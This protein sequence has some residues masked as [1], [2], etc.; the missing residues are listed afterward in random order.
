M[1]AYDRTFY[2]VNLL[3][4][5]GAPKEQDGIEVNRMIKFKDWI[6]HLKKLSIGAVLF[7][8][9]FTSDTDGRD[10]TNYSQIDP[11]LGNN[12]DFYNLVKELHRN[13]IKVVLEAPFSRV[14]KN[15]DPYVNAYRL[16]EASPFY[17]WFVHDES[18]D[19]ENTIR[20]NFADPNIEDFVLDRLEDWID[21]FE[22]DGVILNESSYMHSKFITSI[23]RCVYEMKKDFLL[24]GGV[25]HGDYNKILI[26]SM[27]DSITNFE[28]KAGFYE[29]FNNI[30]MFNIIHTL[31][32]QFGSEKW[33]T[34][35]DKHLLVSASGGYEPRVA[36]AINNPDH[37]KLL[38]GM[39]I[40]I[41]GIPCIYFGDEWGMH[42]GDEIDGPQWNELTEM[43]GHAIKVRRMSQALKYGTF[44]SLLLNNNQCLFERKY[45]NERILVAIN[46]SEAAY[47]IRFK[48]GFKYGTELIE[49][50][51]LEFKDKLTIEPN[52]VFYWKDDGS[53]GF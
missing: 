23:R 26:P 38:F 33:N 11:R 1:W 46:S 35:T 28:V 40:A 39:L 24:I 49:G 16:K 41:P 53:A 29:C 5:C 30:N 10:T 43:I 50:E 18:N 12:V 22:I 27:L 6:P 42:E 17:N 52:S 21:D 31:E 8:N 15:F 32:R 13:G 45:D 3:K 25:E 14:S 34:Y 48:M 2:E 44:R 19:S 7:D 51:M 36:D 47:S 37:I 20:V 4:L 9:V